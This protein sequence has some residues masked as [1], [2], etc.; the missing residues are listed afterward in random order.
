M[1]KNDVRLEMIHPSYVELMQIINHAV[2]VG[3]EPMVNSRYTIVAACAKRA[4]QLID[5]AEPLIEDAEG[6]KPITIAVH[7]LA[8]GKL[9][10]LTEDEAEQARIEAEAAALAAEESLLE[11]DEAETILGDESEEA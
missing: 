3:E 9:K 8:E 2:E 1:A 4:R 11:E 10:I 5:G 7:E 6:M